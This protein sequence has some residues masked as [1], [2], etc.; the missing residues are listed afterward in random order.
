[1]N[2]VVR[3]GNTIQLNCSTNLTVPVIWDYIDSAGIPVTIFRADGEIIE[4][5]QPNFSV[6][7]DEAGTYN[8]V[9]RNVSLSHGGTYRCIDDRGHGYGGRELDKDRLAGLWDEA[10]VVII[11]KYCT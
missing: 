6:R 1:M 4:S 5:F 8:L 2:A 9:I 7:R 11:G 3:E 10:E